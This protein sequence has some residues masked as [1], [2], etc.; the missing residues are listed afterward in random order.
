MRNDFRKLQLVNN[1]LMLRVFRPTD[2]QK[3]TNKEIRSS[4][5]EIKKLAERLRLNFGFAKTTLVLTDEI[6]LHKGLDRL[7]DAVVSF[8]QNPLF[9]QPRVWDVELASRA[10]KDLGQILELA[11]VLRKLVKKN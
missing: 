1:Q 4:L 8:V 9:Q 3:I 5:G 2:A 7:D 10:E 6:V 11:D